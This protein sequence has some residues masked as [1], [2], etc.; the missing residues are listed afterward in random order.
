[1]PEIK[2]INHSLASPAVAAMNAGPER[3][4]LMS[5]L[6]AFAF[7]IPDKNQPSKQ[8]YD[9]YMRELG[10]D[11]STLSSKLEDV[12]FF[13][14][15][16]EVVVAFAGSDFNRQDHIARNRATQP[17]G[18]RAK[19][20]LGDSMHIA[21]PGT[22]RGM[23]STIASTQDA[24][25]CRTLL[26]GVK[27]TLKT[28]SQNQPRK[29]SFVGS[30]AG[31]A[32]AVL[33]AAK[34][35]ADGFFTDTRLELGE[36]YTFGAPRCFVGNKSV[37]F[38][39]QQLPNYYRVEL[40]G[41]P[42]PSMPLSLH[43][44][45]RYHHAG[46]LISL[47][48]DGHVL[49]LG[50]FEDGSN[51]RLHSLLSVLK[52]GGIQ[53][54]LAR[55]HT[56]ARY[57]TSLGRVLRREH[58]E[59]CT[60]EKQSELLDQFKALHEGLLRPTK[61]SI[62]AHR[63]ARATY[64]ENSL[65]AFKEALNQSM[66]DPTQPFM[67]ETDLRMTHD[68][69]LILM[70]D[71]T[72][73]RTL[74]GTGRVD[75]M[76]LAEI[77]KKGMQS[78]EAVWRAEKAPPMNQKDRHFDISPA[79]QRVIELDSLLDLVEQ[80]NKVRLSQG[81]EPVGLALELK[82]PG[83]GLS[84][85][86]R[87]TVKLISGLLCSLGMEKLLPTSFRDLNTLSP[88]AQK[89]NQWTQTHPDHTLKLLT[90]NTWGA[91]GKYNQQQLWKELS[92]ETKTLF[93][94]EDVAATETINH[95]PIDRAKLSIMPKTTLFQRVR[96]AF[97]SM[98]GSFAYMHHFPEPESDE[99]PQIRTTV[100][101]LRERDNMKEILLRGVEFVTT[102]Y[103]DRLMDEAIALHSRHQCHT[104]EP[105]IDIAQSLEPS[106]EVK[107]NHKQQTPTAHLSSAEIISQL[108]GAL[109]TNVSQRR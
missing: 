35:R 87:G 66:R 107:T 55:Y 84:T 52:S 24:Q 79:D 101:P 51:T 90:F 36:V 102:D 28:L 83:G 39:N 30:S 109:E 1:M 62:I 5:W 108:S 25:H 75:E 67:I 38:I 7:N 74:N 34:L 31:G 70:H 43:P 100:I 20:R 37:E 22:L 40:K 53:K 56:P 12:K 96:E 95:A 80:A 44:A 32:L 85:Y 21:Y 27:N 29:V 4:Y 94:S 16:K 45:R 42:V 47:D 11:Y 23:R 9:S 18:Q 48:T 65:A 54:D 14:N 13:I 81:G 63:G 77:Q 89:L 46:Q 41:D 64:P 92:N 61:P 10:Y 19:V 2:H 68:G 6:L 33:T 57:V 49:S 15:D 88:L 3:L 97:I 86:V 78:H 72:I 103:P 105:H 82:R 50:S 60:D 99:M 69:K 17:I 106:I 73:D 58:A 26:D 104:S 91:L 93:N 59:G 8:R 76:T 71:E 98:M